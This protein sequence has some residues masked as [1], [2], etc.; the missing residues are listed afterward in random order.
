MTSRIN[1]QKVNAEETQV[2]DGDVLLGSIKRESPPPGVPFPWIYRFWPKSTGPYS[3]LGAFA[4]LV[5]LKKK[6]EER[7]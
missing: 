1:Y 7:A 2:F 4:E 3:S 6:I 5:Q